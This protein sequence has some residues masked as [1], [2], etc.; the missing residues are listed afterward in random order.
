MQRIRFGDDGLQGP[1]YPTRFLA[2]LV[3]G[4]EH[5]SIN[6]IQAVFGVEEYKYS[7]KPVEREYKPPHKRIGEVCSAHSLLVRT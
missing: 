5:H 7:T 3:E 4:A 1:T 6:F 2:L